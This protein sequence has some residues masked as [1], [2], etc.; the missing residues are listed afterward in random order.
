MEKIRKYPFAPLV[1]R[2]VFVVQPGLGSVRR[3]FL[4]DLGPFP[5]YDLWP[6]DAGNHP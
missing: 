3:V 5:L 6:V 1:L 4:A 2:H